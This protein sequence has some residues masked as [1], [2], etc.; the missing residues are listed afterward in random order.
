MNLIFHDRTSVAP[1]PGAAVLT[2]ER[3][4]NF[5]FSA[6]AVRRLQ[7]VVDGLALPVQDADS[8]Q[9]YMLLHGGPAMVNRKPF[10]LRAVGGKSGSRLVFSST[11]RARAYYAANNVPD[12]VNAVHL[13]IETEPIHQDFVGQLYPLTPQRESAA[14]IA[15]AVAAVPLAKAEQTPGS[16]LET[17]VER[18]R[19]TVRTLG[20]LNLSRAN[21]MTKARALGL[22]S[23]HEAL[24]PSVK[25]AV[26]LLDALKGEK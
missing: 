17:T 8:N 6:G 3:K 2:I 4:G 20:G 16:P 9:W 25:G 10:T 21:E 26:E 11:T 22:L 13:A 7:L 19:A 15:K 5:Y 24:L 14:A 12:T 18:I 23:K 1:E